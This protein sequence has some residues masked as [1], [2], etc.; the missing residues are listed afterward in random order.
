M[1]TILPMPTSG[2]PS[3]GFPATTRNRATFTPRSVL[4][5]AGDRTSGVMSF[6]ARERS[7]TLPSSSMRPGFS[8]PARPEATSFMR[9]PGV[10]GHVDGPR[11]S[12]GARL[13]GTLGRGTPQGPMPQPRSRRQD[14][15]LA[16]GLRIEELVSLLRL[17]EL[18][19]VRKELL[20][21]H[22]VVRDEL[23]ALGLAL[24]RERPG[25]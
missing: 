1:H 3:R 22:A 10:R 6:T 9:P 16:R 19:A 23:G 20:H 5:P 8:A 12:R 13:I 18:P 21:I 2:G 4:S 11:A 17:L 15:G 7:R 24:F 14:D 25:A